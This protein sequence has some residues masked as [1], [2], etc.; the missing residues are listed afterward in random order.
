LTC[1]LCVSMTI[2]MTTNASTA[3]ASIY[4]SMELDP[5]LRTCQSIKSW[6]SLLDRGFSCSFWSDSFHLLSPKRDTTTIPHFLGSTK[7]RNS[8]REGRVKCNLAS[9]SQSPCLPR[10]AHSTRGKEESSPQKNLTTRPVSGILASSFKFVQSRWDRTDA[11]LQQ[12]A[13]P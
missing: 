12:Y 1:E 2:G 10:S 3:N 6:L 5:P 8:L 11:R 9:P 4:D 13:G 7:L